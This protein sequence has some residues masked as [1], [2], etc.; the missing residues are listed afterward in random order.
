MHGLHGGGEYLLEGA[1]GF[2]LFSLEGVNCKNVNP[3]VKE[4]DSLEQIHLEILT[5]GRTFE[6]EEKQAI[7][8]PCLVDH[9]GEIDQK[10]IKLE[11]QVVQWRRFK[12]CG[13]E[14]M[15]NGQ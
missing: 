4:S 12:C 3:Q 8:L 1:A 7:V 13:A 5:E 9:L 6:V 2:T 14:W 11:Q 10:E 15:H